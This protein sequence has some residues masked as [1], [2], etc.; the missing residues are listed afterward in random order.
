MTTSKPGNQSP[1]K[2]QTRPSVAQK[3]GLSRVSHH[4]H[5][6]LTTTQYCNKTELAIFEDS[7]LT[8]PLR[9][10]QMSGTGSNRPLWSILT[11]DPVLPIVPMAYPDDEVALAE[12]L[13]GNHRMT[14]CNWMEDWHYEKRYRLPWVADLASLPTSVLVQTRLKLFGQYGGMQIDEDGR[15]VENYTAFEWMHGCLWP[16]PFR[17]EMEQRI[18]STN[19]L[20]ALFGQ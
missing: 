18:S 17:K 1:K 6:E 8:M 12:G 3:N 16:G 4:N 20:V 10:G 5:E 11:I 15:L 9:Y 13:P 19:K 14:L 2:Q 7:G